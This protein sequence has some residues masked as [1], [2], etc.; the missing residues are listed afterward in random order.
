MKKYILFLLLAPGVM[1]AMDTQEGNDLVAVLKKEF[2]EIL[3][4]HTGTQRIESLEYHIGKIQNY[5]PRARGL[6]EKESLLGLLRIIQQRCRQEQMAVEAQTQSNIPGG[7][8]RN[9][10]PKKSTVTVA[11]NL[12]P[13]LEALL[14]IEND[15]DSA[16]TPDEIG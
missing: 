6:D 4:G 5:A 1:C 7:F 12:L 9:L 10:F 16:P 14:C 8:A 2:R 3:E 11:R 15:S 13:E